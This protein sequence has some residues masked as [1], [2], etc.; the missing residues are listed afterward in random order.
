MDTRGFFKKHF[1]LEKVNKAR[2]TIKGK[3]AKGE[4]K[5][6]NQ[7]EKVLVAIKGKR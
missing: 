3:R 1:F 5:G 7:C 6:G 2:R 4:E